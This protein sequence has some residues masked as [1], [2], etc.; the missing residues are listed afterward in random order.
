MKHYKTKACGTCSAKTLCTKNKAGR[1]IERSE[2]APFIEQN[3]LNIEANTNLYKKRQAIIEHTYGIIK[4]QWGFY[5]IMTKKW[6]HRAGAD[7]GLIFTAFNLR[8]IMNIVQK[9]VIKKFL[10]GLVF[11]FS[12]NTLRINQ[13]KVIELIPIFEK[14]KL[15]YFSRAA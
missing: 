14:Q 9:N 6:K 10:Q 13:I 8:R 2:H 12:R 5:Y 1:L 11:L 15:N 7:V 3:K 4:R